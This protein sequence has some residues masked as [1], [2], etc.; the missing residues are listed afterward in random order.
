[1]VVSEGGFEL[2][3]IK[4]SLPPR[5]LCLQQGLSPDCDITVSTTVTPTSTDLR[6]VDTGTIVAQALIG[7]YSN[8]TVVH[9]GWCGVR[10][11]AD[12]WNVEQY[13]S[14]YGT[15]DNI[16]DGDQQREI[17]VTSQ[18]HIDNVTRSEEVDRISVRSRLL[19]LIKM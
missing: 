19:N 5:Y 16:Q 3:Q 12:N 1:M 8:G 2:L 10:I 13:V 11:S 15:Q 18:Y 17:V 14:I 7:G 9:S 4:A 6:C